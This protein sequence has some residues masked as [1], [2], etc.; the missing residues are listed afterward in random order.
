MKENGGDTARI[1]AKLD[2]L[3]RLFALMVITDKKSLKESAVHLQRAGLGPK[4]IAALCDSTPN[5]VS[6]ALSN[7]KKEGK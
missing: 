6:V 3:I 2:T 1:E 4:E 5:A 7:A